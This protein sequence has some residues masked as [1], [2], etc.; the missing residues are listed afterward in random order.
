M[1]QHEI[2]QIGFSGLYFLRKDGN[3]YSHSEIID[4][5]IIRIIECD[6]DEKWMKVKS[7][8][9]NSLECDELDF[10]EVKKGIII[11][12]N[13]NGERWEGASLKD[14]P[15]GYGCLYNENNQ[16]IYKGFVFEGMKVC[17]GVEFY[18]D[19]GIVEYEGE[20]YQNNRCGYGRLY[21]KKNELV[22]DG[23]WFMNQP[24][25]ISCRIEEEFKEFDIH[26]GIEELKVCNKCKCDLDAIHLINY[27]D[28]KRI[29]IGR[30]CFEN[31][32]VFEVENCNSLT[33][34]RIGSYCFSSEED[35]M[36]RGLFSIRNCEKLNELIIAKMS[37]NNE[38][39]YLEL[40]SKY[41]E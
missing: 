35:K 28:L 12:L 1:N 5:D 11:D 34:I 17:F 7:H 19:V 9:S 25:S 21:N 31:V 33:S 29:E 15:F 16:L 37:C 10:N 30:S 2:Y 14:S 3:V 23:K 27:S 40:N 36:N 38:M 8:Q 32:T 41:E 20:Y 26:F 18:G 4:N 22:Y 6:K 24:L 13:E 39:H